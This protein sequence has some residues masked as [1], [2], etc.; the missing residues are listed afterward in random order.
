MSFTTPTM[1]MNLYRVEI[2]HHIDLI[3]DG[4]LRILPNYN[5]S[6]FMH[7]EIFPSTRVGR[8]ETLPHLENYVELEYGQYYKI[9]LS[10]YTWNRCVARIFINEQSIGAWEI[11]SRGHVIIDRP[12]TLIDYQNSYFVENKL[13][14]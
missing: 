10:N 3:K 11:E 6:P 9:K 8:W 2:V 5:D 4:D 12:K 13:R 14:F 1:E 7:P